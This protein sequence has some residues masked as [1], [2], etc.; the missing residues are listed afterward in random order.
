M[1]KRI[2]MLLALT[3]LLSL[4]AVPAA[5]AAETDPPAAG[6]ASS[7]DMDATQETP[8]AED[9]LPAELTPEQLLMTVTMLMR[10]REA[11]PV[12]TQL[13]SII[14]AVGELKKDEKN[15]QLS[16]KDM[17]AVCFYTI[18]R[19]AEI[20]YDETAKA[21][22]CSW[23]YTNEDGTELKMAMNTETIGWVLTVKTV[24]DKVTTTRTVSV[25][26]ILAHQNGSSASGTAPYF[27][28]CT[29]PSNTFAN[30]SPSIFSFSNSIPATTCNLSIW[31]FNMFSAL[32]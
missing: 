11:L 24:N 29:Y 18:E 25:N 4:I 32:S 3:M 13:D 28:F 9:A 30:S 16:S 7:T 23:T 27:I 2:S 17:L 14:K 8:S 1:K 21:I 6:T 26:W 5:Y 12:E 10:V 20:T 15:I 31:S 22:I 19:G